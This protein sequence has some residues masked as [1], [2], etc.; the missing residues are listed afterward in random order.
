[1]ICVKYGGRK[2][3]EQSEGRE[4]FVCTN[5]KYSKPIAGIGGIQTQMLISQIQKKI[6]TAFVKKKTFK[7]AKNAFASSK[8]LPYPKLEGEVT[9]DVTIM[10]GDPAGMPAPAD[11]PTPPNFNS[12]SNRNNEL[13]TMN[14]DLFMKKMRLL[15]GDCL[16][17]QLMRKSSKF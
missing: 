17:I 7:N 13:H 16:K 5:Y 11:M 1:M 10:T 6:A 14:D 2:S 3:Q 12:V 15:G 8:L 9:Q 4:I